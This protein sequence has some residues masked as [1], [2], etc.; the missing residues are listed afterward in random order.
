M[1]LAGGPET[2]TFLERMRDGRPAIQVGLS[3]PSTVVAELIARSGFDG[4]WLDLQ[5]GTLE[6]GDLFP[7]IAVI[8]AYGVTATVRVGGIDPAAIGRVL[9]AGADVGRLP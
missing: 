2:S 6:V 7:L 3:T 8:R 9:D 5:H 4:V 1:T